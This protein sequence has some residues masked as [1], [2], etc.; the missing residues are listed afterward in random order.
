MEQ[1]AIRLHLNLDD[2]Y[3]GVLLASKRLNVRLRPELR[4]GEN[5]DADEIVERTVREG[6]LDDPATLLGLL[7]EIRFHCLP[8]SLLNSMLST[9]TDRFWGMEP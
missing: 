3:F 5:F 8:E 4:G 6:D 2:L 9:L 1:E 7:L